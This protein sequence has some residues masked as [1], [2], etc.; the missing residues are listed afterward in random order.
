[1][2]HVY[3]MEN[4]VLQDAVSQIPDR[5]F[6]RSGHAGVLCIL[7]HLYCRRKCLLKLSCLSFHIFYKFF[8]YFTLRLWANVTRLNVTTTNANGLGTTNGVTSG[9]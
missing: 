3:N 6:L 4:I 8:I 5:N 9:E 1:M 7:V 2:A